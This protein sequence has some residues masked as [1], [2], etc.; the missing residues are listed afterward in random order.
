M[1][2]SYKGQ[3]VPFSGN[4]DALLP[5]PPPF[6][7]PLPGFII[8]WNLTRPVGFNLLAF[9]SAPTPAGPW[10]SWVVLPASLL[11]GGPFGLLYYRG[12][13]TNGTLFTGYSNNILTTA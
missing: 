1:G 13:F 4:P 9:E 3:A 6:L 12:R 10:T 5:Q 2:H 8:T 7:Q 11:S